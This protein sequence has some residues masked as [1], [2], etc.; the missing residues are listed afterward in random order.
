MSLTIDEIKEV[1][2]VAVSTSSNLSLNQVFLL[3]CIT[4]IALFLGAYLTVKAKNIATKEDI[5]HITSEI[6]KVKS[7]YAESLEKMKTDLQ[8]KSVLQ[9]AFQSKCL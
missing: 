9:S 4:A 8:I 1:V 6:E 7:S 2:E 3:I 5:S